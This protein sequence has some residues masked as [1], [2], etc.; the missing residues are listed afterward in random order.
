MKLQ[1]AHNLEHFFSLF[2]HRIVEIS[3]AIECHWLPFGLRIKIIEERF[4]ITSWLLKEGDFDLLSALKLNQPER[5]WGIPHRVFIIRHRPYVSAWCP[6]ES[7][8]LFLFRLCQRQ[9]Q[10]LSQLPKGAG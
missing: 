5:F 7:D 10:F 1:L 6:K 4:L 8:G 9:R 3:T 2:N